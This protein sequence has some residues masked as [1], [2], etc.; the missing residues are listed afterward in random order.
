VTR[1]MF[2]GVRGQKKNATGSITKPHFEVTLQDRRLFFNPEIPL[3]SRES[4]A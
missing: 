1:F 4:S 2:F 3:L